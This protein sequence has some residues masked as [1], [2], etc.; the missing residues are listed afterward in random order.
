M[1]DVVPH[2]N[3]NILDARQTICV[4]FR[5]IQAE[6][7]VVQTVQAVIILETLHVVMEI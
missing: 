1:M 2:A 6:V 4:L 5:Q 7:H 3:L